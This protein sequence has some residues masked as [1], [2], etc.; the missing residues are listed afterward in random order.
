[1]S[2]HYIYVRCQR[3]GKSESVYTGDVMTYEFDDADWE[4]EFIA[5]SKCL[6]CK[7]ALDDPT[8]HTVISKEVKD[9]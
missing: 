3:C 5:V 1:M 2:S 7:Q 8:Q 4:G 9:A 6:A